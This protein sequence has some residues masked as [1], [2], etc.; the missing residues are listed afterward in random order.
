MLG[1]QL[2]PQ[3]TPAHKD[4][5]VSLVLQV[6]LELWVLQDPLDKQAIVEDQ[7]LQVQMDKRALQ[8][9]LGSQGL[10]DLQASRELEETSDLVVSL[11]TMVSKDQ[12][13]R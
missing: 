11:E 2:E 8:G 13:D 6:M 5:R 7:D 3:E 9:H 1:V 4:R 10:Q 12:Q